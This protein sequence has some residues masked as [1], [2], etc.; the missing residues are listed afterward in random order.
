MPK[1]SREVSGPMVFSSERGTPRPAKTDLRMV[2][3]PTWGGFD[4]KDVVKEVDEVGYGGVVGEDPAK[5]I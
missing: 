2:R 5:G 1:N 4:Y 3:P